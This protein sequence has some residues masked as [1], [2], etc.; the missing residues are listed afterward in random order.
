VGQ[1]AL[2]ETELSAVRYTADDV[3]EADLRDLSPTVVETCS[4]LALSLREGDLPAAER[5]FSFVLDQIPDLRLV[6]AD[7]LRPLIASEAQQSPTPDACRRLVRTCADLLLGL[8]RPTPAH[9]TPGVVLYAPGPGVEALT[10]LMVAVL[11]NDAHV[12][13]SLVLDG[14]E[15]S[16][17]RRV[18]GERG[19]AVCMSGP[20][21]SWMKQSEQ[22]IRSLR[23]GRTAV[24]LVGDGL[25]GAPD[26]ARELGASAGARHLGDAADLLL[27]LRGP[28]TSAEAEVLRLAGDGYTNWRIAHEIGVSV[29]A[30]KSR[31]EA[32]YLKLGAADRTH[33]VAIALRQRWIR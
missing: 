7:V 19:S 18:R 4:A 24:V 26:L 13:S 9:G 23:A 14:D 25:R 22:L 8:R 27:Y 2:V 17:R 3:A 10:L 32:S 21:V 31:L 1:D 11:L 29:S 28:L 30:V 6:L 33:A 20:D 16:L 12:P 5:L 15:E